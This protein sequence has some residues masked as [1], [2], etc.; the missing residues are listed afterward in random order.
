VRPGG[1]DEPLRRPVVDV[2]EALEAPFGV[3]DDVEE[4]ATVEL[5]VGEVLEQD[6]DRVDGGALELLPGQRGA[7]HSRELV[8]LLTHDDAEMLEAHPVDTLVNRRD[9][10]DPRD[11]SPVEDN[12]RL[13]EHDQG[14]RTPVPDALPV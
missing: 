6:V 12:E 2:D 4:G 3:L 11:R 9:E 8:E 1:G 13:G 10:L 14:D 7:M 5:H